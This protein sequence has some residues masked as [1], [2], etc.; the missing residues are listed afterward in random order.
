LVLLVSFLGGLQML[1]LGV[2]GE[3][4]GR[5][6]EQV[7]NRPRYLIKEQIGFSCSGQ[8]RAA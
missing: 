6:H 3:Y 2:V 4:I 8:S 5:I 7:K 1:C